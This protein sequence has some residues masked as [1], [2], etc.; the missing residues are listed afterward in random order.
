MSRVRHENIALFMGACTATGHL[1]LVTR[2][3]PTGRVI[4]RGILYYI[5]VSILKV[6]YSL[7]YE[8][9]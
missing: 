8:V 1:A 6:M 2:W 9:G 7:Q 5:I 4:Q 3:V